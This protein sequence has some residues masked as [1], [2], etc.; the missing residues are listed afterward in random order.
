MSGKV[1][2]GR[3]L[4]ALIPTAMKNEMA[5]SGNYKLLPL[6]KIFP[7]PLQPRQAFDQAGLQELAESLKNQG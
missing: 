7:N 1:V 5:E 3:G 6:E 4:D 2:L